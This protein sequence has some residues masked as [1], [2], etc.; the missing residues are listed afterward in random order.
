MAVIGSIVWRIS[1]TE[2]RL[3]ASVADTGTWEVRLA[4][5]THRS[6][7]LVVVQV[8]L[9]PERF[10]SLA[11]V[12]ELAAEA[13]A[14]ADVVA[15]AAPLPYAHIGGGSGAGAVRHA[16]DVRVVA[17]ARLDG[18]LGTRAW[19]RVRHACARYRVDERCFPA[20]CSRSLLLVPTFDSSLI[21][22]TS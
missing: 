20:T 10:S 14:K 9:L 2:W 18:A 12:D 3:G 21:L 11:G 13:E 8:H 7:S 16:V 4:Y 1:T 6:A 5:D 19:H 22:S 17:G 15:A